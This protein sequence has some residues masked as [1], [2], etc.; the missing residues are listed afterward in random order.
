MGFLVLIDLATR[1][2]LA[3][4]ISLFQAEMAFSGRKNFFQILVKYP[5]ILVCFG[6]KKGM[7]FKLGLEIS[8]RGPSGAP[9]G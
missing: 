8:P 1:W 7:K 5:E 2:I 6:T 3:I 9:R 4:F